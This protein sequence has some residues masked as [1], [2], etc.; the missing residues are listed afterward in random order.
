MVFLRP[1]RQMPDNTWSGYDRVL[2]DTC[3]PMSKPTARHCIVLILTAP[4]SQHCPVAQSFQLSHSSELLITSEPVDRFYLIS[5]ILKEKSTMEMFWLAEQEQGMKVGSRGNTKQICCEEYTSRWYSSDVEIPR[6]LTIQM[7]R[8]ILYFIWSAHICCCLYIFFNS[9][10]AIKRRKTKL[11]ATA[12]HHA[13][14][15][16]WIGF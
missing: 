16:R 12:R 15:R 10:G 8:E 1:S 5:F 6:D 11:A 7:G 2:L 9:S 3:Q 4:L 13:P 14:N